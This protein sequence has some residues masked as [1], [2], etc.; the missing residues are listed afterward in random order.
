MQIYKTFK[1]R[2]DKRLI[3]RITDVKKTKKKTK[4]TYTDGVNP[5]SCR[6]NRNPKRFV[7]PTLPNS[8]TTL[9]P[10]DSDDYKSASAKG[11]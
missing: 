10:R 3:E 7:N 9:G 2:I 1:A 8:R 11:Q 4:Q 6:V 5:T